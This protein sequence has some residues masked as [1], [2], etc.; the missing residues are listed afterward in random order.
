MRKHSKIVLSSFAKVGTKTVAKSLHKRLPHEHTQSM[1][2]I[3][4]ML[5]VGDHLFFCGIRDFVG[6]NMSYFFQI[7]VDPSFNN[8]Q[9]SSNDYNGERCYIGDRNSVLKTSVDDLISIFW[10]DINHSTSLIWFRDFFK[11]MGF[12]IGEEDFPN[13]LGYCEYPIKNDNAL[14]LY[15]LDSVE[16]MI[17]SNKA[18]FGRLRNE[19]ISHKKWYANK[20]MEFKSRI[21]FKD[22]YVNEQIDNEI[23]SF[24]Y[25]ENERMALKQKYL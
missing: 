9:C 1:I 8:V 24:F 18:L 23:M 3:G 14:I 4:Q 16:K 22:A 11:L 21:Q 17:L 15:R 25:T 20:Y 2:R 7:M 12:E 19:N 6:R 5:D 10:S 13:D